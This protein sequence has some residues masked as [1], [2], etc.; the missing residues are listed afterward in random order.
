M[1]FDTIDLMKTSV[2]ETETSSSMQVT[3]DIGPRC[4]YD[5]SYC[6]TYRHDNHSKHATLDELKSSADFI[7]KY[8]DLCMALRL[9]KQVSINFTG[10]EPTTN[11]NFIKI[12]KYIKIRYKENHASNWKLY[13]SLTSNGAMGVKQAAKIIENFDHLTIS[14]HTEADR[15]LKKQFTD[16]MLQFKEAV[17]ADL[18]TRLSVNVMFHAQFFDECIDMCAW[19][20]KHNIAYVPRVIGEEADSKPT[21]AHKYNPEQLDWLKSYWKVNALSEHTVDESRVGAEIQHSVSA[22][23]K[24]KSEPHKLGL[25]VGRPCCGGQMMCLSGGAKEPRES[26]YVDFRNFTGWNCSVNWFFLH[27][28]QHTG[29]IFHHQTCK[30]RFVEKSG[31]IGNLKSYNPILVNLKSAIELKQMPTIIC[32]KKTCGCGLCAPKSA[33]REK[34]MEVLSNHLDMDIFKNSPTP[35]LKLPTLIPGVNVAIPADDT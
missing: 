28:E 35:R 3:W 19:F 8:L 22:V 9:S 7:F 16:R 14:Y 12:V 29:D 30:A 20:D 21:F 32:S 15:K 1:S 11:P 33:Y 26:R 27:I 10:G 13:L 18:L 5:C 23:N 25:D 34:Y 17:D 24:T 4:N 2:Q 31:P 6:P